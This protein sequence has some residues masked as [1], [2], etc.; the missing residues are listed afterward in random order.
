MAPP[1]CQEIVTGRGEPD[2]QSYRVGFRTISERLPA[3]QP[4]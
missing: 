4:M 1:D 3:F 2:P